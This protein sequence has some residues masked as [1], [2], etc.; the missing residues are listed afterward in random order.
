MHTPC[1]YILELKCFF[2]DHPIF[3]V[4]IIFIIIIFF[5]RIIELNHLDFYPFTR[6]NLYIFYPIIRRFV[7]IIE[8]HLI[9][10]FPQNSN[11]RKPNNIESN[12]FHSAI[13]YQTCK[14]SRTLYFLI[15]FF[16]YFII[17]RLMLAMIVESLGC[18]YF[19]MMPLK[20]PCLSKKT[21]KSGPSIKALKLEWFDCILIK[22]WSIN[23]KRLL[24]HILS[25][26][27]L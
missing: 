3:S 8:N 27:G 11:T 13:V 19:I 2:S 10:T 14:L 18:Q 4:F 25:F 17:I 23:I 9:T 20:S 15:L 7:F 24:C 16:L 6:Q 21:L 5:W 26:K 12:L 22:S 1:S